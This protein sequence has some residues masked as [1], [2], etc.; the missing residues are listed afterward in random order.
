MNFRWLQ[1]LATAASVIAAIYLLSI[2]VTGGY[3][4][5]FA[6][7]RFDANKL[8]PAIVATL[9]F[10]LLHTVFRNGSIEGACKSSPG[11]I[12]FSVALIVFLANGRTI[13]GGDSVPAKNLPL[14]ILG[15]GHFYLDQLVTPGEK[16]IPYYLRES[17]GHY[18]SD[19]P[20]GAALIALPF[21]APSIVCGVSP[22]S[23]IFSELEKVS[24]ATIV[25][26][27]VL[28]LY[29][30]AA[31]VTADWMAM[32]LTLVYA[33]GTTSLSVSSQALWQHGPAQLALTAAIYCLV[34][35]RDES[36]WAG[37]AGLPLAF[38]VITRPA[39]VLIAAPLGLYVLVSYRREI[40]TF[41]AT[42]IAPVLFQ[43]WYNATYFGTPFRSQFFTQ[44]ASVGGQ[45]VPSAG[46]WAT[47]LAR[48][49][50]VVVLSPGRGL[51][52]YSPI[53]ILS[54]A[55]LALA[56]RKNGEV[57]LRYLGICAILSI[58]LVAKW[59]KSSGGESFG[60]RLL[61]D[62]TPIM[63]FALIPLADC[64]RNRRALVV[65]FAVLGVW[66][67]AANASGAFISYRAWNNWTLGDPDTRLWLWGDNPVVDPMR[68]TFDSMRIAL[69]HRATSRN[70]PDTL[71]AL[72][73]TLSAPPPE[74]APG[75]RVH[76]SIRATNTGKAVWL[77]GHSPDERGVVSLG[78][79]WKRDGKEIADSEVRRELH[80]NVFP[81]DSMELEASAI[82]PDAPGRYEL[83]IS[84]A[85]QTA[86]QIA[87]PIGT[88]L[89][90]AVTV[91]PSI[92]STR[93]YFPG[94]VSKCTQK[95]VPRTA[96][97]ALGV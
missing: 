48:G 66:S 75:A 3:A 73:V 4:V 37:Y 45:R 68:S 52:F 57:L 78:W 36:R 69:E 71:D 16:K 17:G 61:A 91:A 1:K 10:A 20:V 14:S 51:L 60:P 59:H 29:M 62:V 40:W 2:L 33:F 64:L 49:L 8:W 46:F 26:L 67:I 80:L 55:G 27:S 19:Y 76:V 58:L 54:F 84:L 94:F 21:Y 95:S 77:T 63:A 47:P 39:D 38:E 79:E 35:A 11:F 31:R 96:P 6:G 25:A 34:R 83:E 65:V 28:L 30:A 12:I 32:L 85:V 86:G 44:A 9:G 74:A 70:S 81:G 92:N 56:W 72:L 5:N 50:A 43:V 13:S 82:T 97:T 15:H 90:V 88:P 41:A 42:A 7:A 89:A 24:A 93:F 53:F 22:S 23:R 18:V 87:R